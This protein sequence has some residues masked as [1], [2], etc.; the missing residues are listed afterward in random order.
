MK[1]YSSIQNFKEVNKQQIYFSQEKKIKK[2]FFNRC[3]KNGCQ[4]IGNKHVIIIHINKKGWFCNSC[5]VELSNNGL[6]KEV[7]L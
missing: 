7:L 4:N 2:R 6:I 1:R 3:A 5:L